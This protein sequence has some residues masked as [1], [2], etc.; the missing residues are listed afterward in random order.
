MLEHPLQ[1]NRLSTQKH[2]FVSIMCV[3]GLLPT[4]VATTQPVSIAFDLTVLKADHTGNRA[5]LF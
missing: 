4:V 3:V 1:A 5:T 2:S